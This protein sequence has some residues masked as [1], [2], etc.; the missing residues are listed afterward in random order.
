[1]AHEFDNLSPRKQY[2]SH[3]RADLLSKLLGEKKDVLWI[4]SYE[5]DIEKLIKR[6]LGFKEWDDNYDCGLHLKDDTIYLMLSKR[7][8]LGSFQEIEKV[9]YS[10]ALEAGTWLLDCLAMHKAYLDR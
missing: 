6:K 8:S 10:N 9:K 3:R 1:M 5:V 7:N 4:Y 2:G